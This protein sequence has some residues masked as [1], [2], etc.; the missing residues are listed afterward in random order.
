MKNSV[1]VLIAGLVILAGGCES[2][3]AQQSDY[4]TRP[5]KIVIGFPAG[6][7]IDIVGRLVGDKLTGILHQPFIIETRPG[8][9]GMVATAAV[10][11]AEPDGYTL[12][13]VNDN[14]A[15]NPSIFK[16]LPYDA[17]K[18]F[19]PIGFIGSVPMIFTAS[20]KFPVHTVQDVVDAARAKPGMITFASIGA[21]SQSHLGV[22]MF[23]SLAGIKMQ[24]VPYHGG[25]PA[26]TDLIAGRVNTMF[27][28]P[29]IGI[30]VMRAGQLTPLATS[31]EVRLEAMPDVPTMAEAG[32]PVDTAS[33]MGLVAP[34]GTPAPIVAKLEKA[35]GEVLAMPDVQKRLSSIGTIVKPL[36][37][38]Q[39]GEYIHAE[40]LRWHDVIVKA[41]IEPQ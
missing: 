1:A 15:I 39:F 11:R 10:A 17:E 21:G 18:D 34:R 9:T 29:V 26:L 7:L 32:Y 40:T 5:V 2:T 33:W 14:H 12:L 19:T 16:N 27:L 8:A 25:A 24:H 6:G 30:P 31:S 41:G 3:W 38:R 13:L 4:P 20:T 37:G 35:L 23:C 28:T 22:E 36:N